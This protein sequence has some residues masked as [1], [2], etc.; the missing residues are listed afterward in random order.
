MRMDSF[1][2]VIRVA[3]EKETEASE[4]YEK[5]SAMAEWS[6]TQMM[7]KELAAEERRHRQML[8]NLSAQEL[9][10]R[11]VQTIPNLRIGDY[12]VETPFTPDMNYQEVLILAI[13]REERAFRMYED[14]G[15]GA[16]DP[17]LQKLFQVLT[18][19]EG[20]HKLR[21]ETEYD[22]HVLTEL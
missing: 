12:L 19:E 7:F 11:E 22:E 15:Q 20:K 5:A 14:L 2:E 8:E 13:K 10:P 17:Q 18:Q 9:S 16:T 1:E 21:L 4:L 6:N 3:I